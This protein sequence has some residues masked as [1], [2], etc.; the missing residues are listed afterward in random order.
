MLFTM[1]EN[2]ISNLL[3]VFVFFFYHL[4]VRSEFF[5]SVLLTLRISSLLITVKSQVV[6]SFQLFQ[7]CQDIVLYQMGA[8][9]TRSLGYD[10][11]QVYS[12][13][14]P[15]SPII[16]LLPSHQILTQGEANVLKGKSR[17]LLE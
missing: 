3:Q 10:L 11:H 12:V 7:V 8:S 14:N 2:T 16:F 17:K 9:M 15:S 1:S 13:T 6:S 5:S 4:L